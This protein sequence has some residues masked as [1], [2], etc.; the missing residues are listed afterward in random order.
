MK[1]L[2]L[3]YLKKRLMVLAIFSSLILITCVII[4]LNNPFTI[5]WY[6]NGNKQTMI[7]TTYSNNLVAIIFIFATIIP[8]YEFSFKMQKNSVDLFYSL[9]IKRYKLYLVKY[10]I[11]LIELFILFTIAF[12]YIYI[13]VSIKS[14]TVD[15]EFDKTYYIIFYFI[16]L[17][18]GII[19]Y[20]WI[21]F[22]FTRGNTIIDGIVISVL[23]VFVVAIIAGSII[24]ICK[25]DGGMNTV[26]SSVDFTPYSAI[27]TFKNSFDYLIK[28]SHRTLPYKEIMISEILIPAMGVIF[29]PL[30]FILN[31]N[32]KA[33]DTSDISNEWY[34]YRLLIPIYIIGLFILCQNQL[35]YDMF[36]II[37][38]YVGYVIYN[39][40]FKIKKSDLITFIAT[41]ALGF[42]ASAIVES[43]R[44]NLKV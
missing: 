7:N 4:T 11:G 37:F 6:A 15:V 34:T 2:F 32:K 24:Y 44:L 36:I 18:L 19:L 5:V 20:S 33:E 8:I 42:I 26:Y 39:R 1:N 12:I 3:Y 30:F 14:T 27:I 31:N 23:S 17:F 10:L 25:T 41:V 40:T 16:F 38:G 21:S 28:N 29:I 43:L 35:V 9:P 22:F 13:F